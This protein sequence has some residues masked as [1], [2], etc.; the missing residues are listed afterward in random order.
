MHRLLIPFALVFSG[1]ASVGIEPANLV[2]SVETGSIAAV[3]PGEAGRP[4]LS[5]SQ[6][7]AVDD[8]RRPLQD[9]LAEK[10]DNCSSPKLK[11]AVS[12]T[13]DTASAMA[14]SMKPDY[15]VMLAV[16]AA[17]LDVADAAKSRGCSRDAKALYDFVL[18]NY[19]GLGYAALRDRAATGIKEL[20]GKG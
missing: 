19:G 13:T 16:G 7:R 6:Q 12:R 3:G 8:A 4:A 15:G 20:H 10:G 17:L 9:F 2:P 18:K 14:T 11:E 1:C 5:K